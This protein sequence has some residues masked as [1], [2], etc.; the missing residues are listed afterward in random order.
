MD[1]EQEVEA[2]VSWRHDPV[3]VSDV[4]RAILLI[5]SVIEWVGVG[6]SPE[7]KRARSLQQSPNLRANMTMHSKHFG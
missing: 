2:S 1:R 4:G 6:K 3:E 5:I 7:S